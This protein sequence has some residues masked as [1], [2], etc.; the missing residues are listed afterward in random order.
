MQGSAQYTSPS[1]S[2]ADALQTAGG[3]HRKERKETL[4]LREQQYK[5]SL[6]KV[7]AYGEE[8]CNVCSVLVSK[9]TRLYDVYFSSILLG[10]IDSSDL[11]LLEDGITQSLQFT[12]DFFFVDD[13]EA[14]SMD[15]PWR[16]MSI[17]GMQ[18][19]S[20]L[21]ICQVSTVATVYMF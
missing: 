5:M 8:G 9:S 4:C 6:R 7:F 15:Y 21:F 16:H 1:S 2:Q 20:L 11:K 18:Q 12:G 13:L 19:S 17:L 10:I 3:E 14:F